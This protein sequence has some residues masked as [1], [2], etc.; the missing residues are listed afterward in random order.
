MNGIEGLMVMPESAEQTQ[1]RS[2]HAGVSEAMAELRRRFL[3]A[4]GCRAR[5]DDFAAVCPSFAPEDV[6]EALHRLAE[7]GEVDIQILAD[8]EAVFCFPMA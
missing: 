4:G 6:V 8:S 3:A 2:R 5:A 7:R 1:M